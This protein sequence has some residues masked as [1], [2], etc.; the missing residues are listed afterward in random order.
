[1]ADVEQMPTTPHPRAYPDPDARRDV[2]GTE[3]WD[4]PQQVR[5]TIGEHTFAARLEVQRAPMTCRVLHGLLPLRGKLLQTR[6]SGEAAWVP[7]AD[8]DI[9]LEYE[10]HTAYPQPGQVLLFRG[11]ISQPEILLPYGATAFA[12]KVGLLAGNHVATMLDDPER[13]ALIGQLV[14][15]EGAQD[16]LIEYHSPTNSS[17]TPHVVEDCCS[18]SDPSSKGSVTHESESQR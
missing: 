17:V 9:S 1:M 15:W 4:G 2:A 10:N 8:Y 12:S 16:I 5:I 18:A 6:W 11:G 13:L 3:P 14:L 7:L